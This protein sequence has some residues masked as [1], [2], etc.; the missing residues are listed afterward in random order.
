MGYLIYL[1]I[2]NVTY[3]SLSQLVMTYIDP[4]TQLKQKSNII[5]KLNHYWEFQLY[6]IVTIEGL[7]WVLQN[8]LEAKTFEESYDSTRN[9]ITNDQC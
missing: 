8:M 2:P 7:K 3:S 4:A 9:A 5:L 1:K 6:F